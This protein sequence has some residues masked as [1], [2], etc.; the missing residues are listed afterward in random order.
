MLKLTNAFAPMLALPICFP[1]LSLIAT[2]CVL[3]VAFQTSAV[4][5]VLPFVSLRYTEPVMLPVTM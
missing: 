4:Y 3:S 1:L 5:T 2:V